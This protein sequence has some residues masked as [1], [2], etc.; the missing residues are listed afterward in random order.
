MQTA[1]LLTDLII[2]MLNQTGWCSGVPLYSRL[3]LRPLQITQ[4][5]HMNEWTRDSTAEI[6]ILSR[7]QWWICKRDSKLSSKNG[8]SRITTNI[9]QVWCHWKCNTVVRRYDWLQITK[10]W[11]LR[12]LAFIGSPCEKSF[13]LVF[14]ST[15]LGHRC[16]ALIILVGIN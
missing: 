16:T 1:L 15:S 7:N 3:I 10:Y 14:S 9:L 6:G 4:Q 5:D 2:P 8:F 11:L 12:P 13:H